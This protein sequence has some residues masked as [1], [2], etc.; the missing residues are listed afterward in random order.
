MEK[1]A[2]LEELY[3]QSDIICIH[4]PLTDE[5]RHFVNAESI[6]KMKDGVKILNLS[7]ADLV[8]DEDIAKALEDGKVAKY[9]TDFPNAKTLA[10]KNCLC[11]PH[12]GASTEESEDNCAYMAAHE[13]IDYLE[14]GNIV[15]SV[16]F[17]SAELARSG[18]TRI[19][20]IHKNVPAILSSISSAISGEHINIENMINKSRG[21]F[22]YTIADCG[23]DVP[24][25]IVSKIAGIGGVI[26]V[27]V[28]K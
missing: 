12:L 7:R 11:I 18:N 27:R 17:P 3:E 9:V 22:A 10:M 8:S 13:L 1:A 5:T 26:R 14:N 20:V 16:N 6:A 19:C 15:N 21:D 28:I 24:D 23:S 25:G 4:A 2:S